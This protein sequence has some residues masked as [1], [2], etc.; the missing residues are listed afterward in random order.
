MN[1]INYGKLRMDKTICLK[2]YIRSDSTLDVFFDNL[3]AVISHDTDKNVYHLII[4]EVSSNRLCEIVPLPPV[5]SM[6]YRIFPR[7]GNKPLQ[8]S[9]LNTN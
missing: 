5:I 3:K 6:N 1:C 8:W 7:K 4:V 2:D 9:D